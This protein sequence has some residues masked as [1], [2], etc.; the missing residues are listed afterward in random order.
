MEVESV[1]KE[2]EVESVLVTG[3]DQGIGLEIVR[4]LVNLTKQLPRYVFA[5]Y[6]DESRLRDLK[7][8][9]DKS[10]ETLVVLIKM[11]VTKAK[12]IQSARKKIEEVVGNR[13]LNLLINN[14]EAVKPKIVPE[15]NEEN[16]MFHF[17]TNT[18][19]PIMMLQEMFPLLKKSSELKKAG[20]EVSRAAVLNISSMKG[21]ITQLDDSK[22]N[23]WHLTMSYRASKAALNMAMRVNALWMMEEGILTV[24][25]CPQRVTTNKEPIET[26]LNVSESVTAMLE[27]LAKL[28]ESHHGAFLDRNG[29]DIP[30]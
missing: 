19:G 6:R 20:L 15:V 12:S 18:V 2:L 29:I 14:E 4:Q 10:K 27:T 26:N 3:A 16:L 8:I 24:N 28:D 23:D 25:M 21:S 13:G 1:Q 9:K 7:Q 17:N 5:T 22:A 30:F 11:D